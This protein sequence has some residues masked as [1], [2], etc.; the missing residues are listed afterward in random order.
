MKA[1]RIGRLV[2]GKRFKYRK[3][4][5]FLLLWDEKERER[6]ENESSNYLGTSDGMLL[7][8]KLD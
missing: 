7:P 2:V 8:R 1:T 3:D 4:S 5:P 6:E